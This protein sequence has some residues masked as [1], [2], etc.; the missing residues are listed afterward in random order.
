[1][2]NTNCNNPNA[3]AEPTRQSQRAAGKRPTE[4]SPALQYCGYDRG[5]PK[6]PP[7]TI[8]GTSART[9]SKRTKENCK[10]PPELL[11]GRPAIQQTN[12]DLS[13]VPAALGGEEVV[14]QPPSATVSK[15][16]TAQPPWIDPQLPPIGGLSPTANMPTL[17]CL[18]ESGKHL[19]RVVDIS[20]N[21]IGAHFSH[22]RG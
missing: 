9:K 10:P 2:A 7:E 1:M 15:E 18:A 3:A 6:D 19:L 13:V 22:P 4:N 11:D 17:L 20:D 12:V 21:L 14:A 5:G 8:V 16:T